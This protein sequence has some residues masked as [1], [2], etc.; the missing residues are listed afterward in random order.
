M[1]SQFQSRA[2]GF[3]KGVKVSFLKI[4]IPEFLEILAFSK[5]TI[6]YPFL[7]HS[8]ALLRE[9]RD[10]PHTQASQVLLSNNILLRQ[11]MVHSE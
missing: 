9:Q 11:R 5:L 7:F 10:F 4:N 8:F 2:G 1:F 6:Y 3:F